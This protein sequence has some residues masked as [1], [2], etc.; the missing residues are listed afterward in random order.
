MLHFFACNNFFCVLK[1]ENQSSK[2]A[3]ESE[4]TDSEEDLPLTVLIKNKERE[5]KEEPQE[6]KEAE[7]Q[8]C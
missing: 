6:M 2:K 1:A 3:E 4:D 7:S 8:V 5:V